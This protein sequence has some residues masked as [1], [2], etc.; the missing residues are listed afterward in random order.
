RAG[1]TYWAFEQVGV[2]DRTM[3]SG[4]D[5][6]VPPGELMSLDGP[7]L[8]YLCNNDSLGEG[9]PNHMKNPNAFDRAIAETFAESVVVNGGAI[10][11]TTFMVLSPSSRAWGTTELWLSSTLKALESLPTNS[12]QRVDIEARINDLRASAT[13]TWEEAIAATLWDYNKGPLHTSFNSWRPDLVAVQGQHRAAALSA[14]Y[15]PRLGLSI[16]RAG[17]LGG[18][19]FADAERTSKMDKLRRNLEKKKIV[20]NVYDFLTHDQAAE[21]RQRTIRQTSTDGSFLDVA[22][23]LGMLVKQLYNPA[24]D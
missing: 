24:A 8:V 12:Q 14:V 6:V 1:A 9:K 4:V 18:G 5:V 19:L 16:S 10:S 13:P 2:F 7:S 22:A 15:A 23:S 11:E 21:A 17:D 20:V 3:A